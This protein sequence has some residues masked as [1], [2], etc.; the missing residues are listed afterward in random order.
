[1]GIKH[2]FLCLYYEGCRLIHKLH[3]IDARNG[4]AMKHGFIR[5]AAATPRFDWQIVLIMP[6]K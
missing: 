4:E 1:M 5:V 2:M 6:S 3:L